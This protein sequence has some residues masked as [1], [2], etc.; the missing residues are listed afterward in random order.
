MRWLPRQQTT[1]AATGLSHRDMQV[2]WRSSTLGGSSSDAHNRR[3]THTTDAHNRRTQRT[4]DAHNRRTQQ[5]HDARNGRNTDEA[6]RPHLIQMNTS[7]SPQND[8]SRAHRCIFGVRA[9]SLVSSQM[10]VAARQRPVTFHLFASTSSLPPLGCRL[11]TTAGAERP[12]AL[13]SSC[14]A[15]M[16]FSVSSSS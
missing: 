15:P 6:R 3:T 2:S 7:L 1:E 4:H 14:Y 9:C 5:T 16:H 8:L 13:A 10:K 11:T 12:P